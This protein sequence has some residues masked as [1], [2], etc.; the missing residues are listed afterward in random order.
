MRFFGSTP[1]PHLREVWNVTRL[2][3]MQC[4]SEWQE[5]L[6]GLAA[7]RDT[8]RGRRQWHPVDAQTGKAP[9]AV[10][11]SFEL[12]WLA[13]ERRVTE[14]L[15]ELVGPACW[16]PR[17]SGVYACV[18][19]ERIVYVGQSSS[20]ASRLAQHAARGLQSAAWI[21]LP[22]D[23]IADK[24]RQLLDLLLPAMNRDPRTRRLRAWRTSSGRLS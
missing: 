20:L 14:A 3:V 22:P 23:Q 11:L 17:E 15:C 18:D 10:P 1:L 5:L 6:D 21:V 24:E 7:V 9:K 13:L 19:G 8:G 16:A 12:R 2:S 4:A